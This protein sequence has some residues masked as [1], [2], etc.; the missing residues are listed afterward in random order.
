MPCFPSSFQIFRALVFFFFVFPPQA[1]IFQGSEGHTSHGRETLRGV[2]GDL[3]RSS[4]RPTGGRCQ[5]IEGGACE[6]SG[7]SSVCQKY[8]TCLQ[9]VRHYCTFLFISQAMI[10]GHER[11]KTMSTAPLIQK[12]ER[13]SGQAGVCRTRWPCSQDRNCCDSPA[14][15]DD[16]D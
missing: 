16:R 7:R 2:H 11:C 4:T 6:G 5:D 15:D 3:S 8:C 1:V 10:L 9:H 12:K 13:Y 14:E